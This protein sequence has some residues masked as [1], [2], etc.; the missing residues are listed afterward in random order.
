MCGIA[1]TIGV[2][3]G[4]AVDGLRG[5]ALVWVLVYPVLSIKLLRDTCAITGM[6]PGDYYRNLLPVLGGVAA[7]AG[8]VLLVRE[9]LLL[10]QAPVAAMLAAEIAAG[11][12]AYFMYIVYI[13]RRGITEIRQ[14][15]VDIG[16]AE[17]RLARWPFTRALTTA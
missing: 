7:M 11:A 17:N 8:V 6:Q 12:F 14:V 1:M 3:V 15:L 4:A 10:A 13:D 16:I 9:G 5:V 2:L